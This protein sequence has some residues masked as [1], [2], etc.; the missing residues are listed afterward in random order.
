[1]EVLMPK[2]NVSSQDDE[3]VKEVCELPISPE[4]LQLFVKFHRARSAEERLNVCAQIAE[5]FSIEYDPT[6][7]DATEDWHHFFEEYDRASLA[8]EQAT[9]KLSR[10]AIHYVTSELERNK[11]SFNEV[12]ETVDQASRSAN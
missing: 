11:V 6:A 10:L 7:Q 4:V 2:V 1:M 8:L 12:L 9:N 3:D 5:Q